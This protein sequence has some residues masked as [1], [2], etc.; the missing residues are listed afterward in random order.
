MPQ[1]NTCVTNGTLPPDIYTANL[2]T[3]LTYN[4]NFDFE[5][6]ADVVVYREQPAGTFTLLTN[7]AATGATPPNYTINEGVSPAQVTFNTNEAPGGVSLVIGRRTGICD[8]IV[9]YQVGAAIRAQDLNASN[10]QLLDL[11]QE[12]RSTLGFMINGNDTD[13]IIPGQGMD[14]GDLDDVTLADPIPNPSLLRWNGTD[15]VNNDVLESG[16][17]WVADNET[18]ATTAAGDARWLGGGATPDVVGGPGVT[19]TPNSPAAGQI[20]VSADLEAAGVGTGGLVFDPTTGN[21]GEIRVN[22]GNGLELTANGVEVDLATPSGLEFNGGDLRIDANSGCEIVAAGLNAETT[23]ASIVQTGGTN[24]DPAIRVATT[25]GTNTTNTDLVINGGANTTV[26]RDSNN[27]LTIASSGGTGLTYRGTVDVTDNTTL[28]TDSSV[29]DIF[30]NDTQGTQTADWQTVI[31]GTSTTANVGDLLQCTTA[32]GG[33]ATNARYTLIESGTPAGGTPNLQAVTTEGNTSS[34]NIL[35]QTGDPAVTNTSLNA[36][37]SAVFNEQG[38]DVD[39]RV[40]GTGQANALVV[41]GTNGNVGIGEGTPAQPLDVNGN[42]TVD[43]TITIEDGNGLILQNADENRTVTVNADDVTTSYTVTLPPAPPADA[44]NRFLAAAGTG[45]GADQELE[46]TTAGALWEANGGNLRP[47]T[48][49]QG[50]QIRNGAAVNTTLIGADGSATFNETGAAVDF[51][52]EGDTDVNLLFVDGS[53]DRV[54]IGTNAPDSTLDVDGQV[55][56]TQNAIAA[57]AGNFNLANGN[58]WTLGAVVIPNPTNMV[59]GMSGLIVNTA[60]ATWPAAGGATFQY[61]AN[62]PPNITEFPAV[63][64]FYCTNNTTIFIGTPTV[65]IV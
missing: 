45:T 10:T 5:A 52:V 30:A 32:A 65:N 34:N 49:T 28:P 21:D 44:N 53:E 2:A 31:T 60:A 12:I 7:S 4:I 51:R 35:L 43:G 62:T 42:V 41:D 56:I 17:A 33:T 64:P 6:E 9:T 24:A 36:D 22:V 13:P 23:T 15:W 8:P 58:F 57:G 19:I 16:D 54:G 40:E 61:A 38:A 46:W 48:D 59:A 39:F 55:T 26:T 25:L 27:Q 1:T 63:I 14:L 3:Q 37:G 18:F 50:V 20:L 29:N 11:I 47:V